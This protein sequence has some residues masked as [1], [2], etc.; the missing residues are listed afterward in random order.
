M[1]YQISP[2]QKQLN[3]RREKRTMKLSNAQSRMMSRLT[4]E[5]QDVH[6]MGPGVTFATA[7]G[8]E[9]KGLVEVRSFGKTKTNDSWWGVR[10][11]KAEHKFQR[12]SATI[13]GFQIHRCQLCDVMGVKDGRGIVASYSANSGVDNVHTVDTIECQRN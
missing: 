11:V 13:A 7:V 2:A 4:S 5:F 6:K 9:K 10:L 12:T 1:S 3:L 8:L